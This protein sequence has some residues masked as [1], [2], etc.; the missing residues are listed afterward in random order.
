[1]K[2]HKLDLL[3]K[4]KKITRDNSISTSNESITDE[5]HLCATCV[6]KLF[7]EWMEK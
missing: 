7:K 2:L 4:L 1:M 6:N 5:I 3:Q